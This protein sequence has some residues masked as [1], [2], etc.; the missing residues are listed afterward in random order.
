MAS[1]FERLKTRKLFN[2]PFFGILPLFVL[3][4]FTHHLLTALP[5]PLLPMIR[6]DFDLDY[7]K[8]GLLISAFSLSYGLGQLP[9]GWLADRVGRRLMLTTG[10]SGVAVAGFCLGLSTSFNTLI[11]FLILMG[12]L[13]GGYHPSASPLITASVEPRH[14]GR[15][16][17][18]HVIGGSA[19]Y[20][21]TPLIGVAI[22]TS[23]GWRASFIG[24]SVP[25][26]LL[27]IILYYLISR[28]SG[29]H[30][31]TK[32]ASGEKYG[33]RPV[34]RNLDLITVI[35]LSS[36]ASAI[37][38][39]IIAFIPLLMTDYHGVSAQSAA[40][41]LAIVYSAGP[42][43]APLGGYLCDRLGPVTMLLAVCFLLA[44]LILLL[45]LLP[46][47][48][49]IIVV[50]LAAGVCL[51]IRMPATE[52]YIVNNTSD[53]HRSTILGVYYFSAMES[54]GVLTPVVGYLIDHYGFPTTFSLAAGS[55]LTIT[56][57]SAL[58]FY[59]IRGIR[60]DTV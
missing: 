28:Q 43:T 38:I 7:T 51:T 13:A 10:I 45:I 2:S 27:G 34:R 26:A 3:A 15:A 9:A 18:F 40:V 1:T 29:I 31:V 11:L 59:K 55:M 8:A 49:G 48:T 5:V 37:I 53:D 17:G 52:A 12:V 56:S 60:R 23:W 16:L 4:H 57:I 35:F 36:G 20:F 39:S 42:W 54:G 47:G 30:D 19:S 21:L 41:Y 46:L 25:T 22:A 24:L 50:L 14:Q 44:P 32:A 33:S 6:S 58:F